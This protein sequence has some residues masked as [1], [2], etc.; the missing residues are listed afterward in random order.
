[1]TSVAAGV[2]DCAYD[3]NDSKSNVDWA[4]AVLAVAVL[5]G[6][7]LAGSVLEATVGD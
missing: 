7:V 1:M 5:A 2:N 6:S 4:V 3:M